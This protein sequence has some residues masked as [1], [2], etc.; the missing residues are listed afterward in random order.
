VLVACKPSDGGA[1]KTTAPAAQAPAP[2]ATV[3]GTPISREA[4]DFYVKTVSGKEASALT[5]EQREQAL[6]NL[7]RG[8]L[9]AQQAAK[10]GIDRQPETASALALSRLEIL[11][12]AA[13]QKYLEGKTPTEQ[14]LRAEYETQVA[15]LPA[16]E[17]K[18]RHILVATEGFAQRL[19]QQLEK[20]AN[21]AEL[22]KR[23]SMDSSKAQGGDLGWFSP[24]RMVK[25][26]ADAVIALP[27]GQ[28]TRTPVQSQFGWHVI[29][30]EDVREAKIPSFEEV[31]PQLA[32]RAQSRVV[33]D[34][35]RSLRAKAG[36][37]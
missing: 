12:Q 6:D 14:E 18:A 33:D 4:F 31:K 9:I 23:E 36:A 20:G 5:A 7:V 8:E 21:F 1:S 28:Y 2:V 27:K 15:A 11:Q 24:D 35:V 37:K 3:N 17:Y 32:Q 16:K 13:R 22:A 19:I 29:Q 10:D 26:F 34:Y 25:P 30:L